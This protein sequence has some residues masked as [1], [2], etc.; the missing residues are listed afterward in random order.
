MDSRA[1]NVLPILRIEQI[2]FDTILDLEVSKMKIMTQ[3][4][5]GMLI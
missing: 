3:N 5:K 2:G 4:F 1:E